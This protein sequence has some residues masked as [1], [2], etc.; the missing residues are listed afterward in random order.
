VVNPRAVHLHSEGKPLVGAVMPA[1]GIA[2]EVRELTPD[3]WPALE[4]LF[5]PNGACGGCWCMYWRL[6]EGERY[7]NVKGA[8]AKRR[9]SALVRH[10]RA[11]GLLA[12]V[13][14]EPVGWCAF[15]RRTELPRLNRAPSLRVDD[16]ERVWSLPC[17]F[18]KARW[19][20]TGV[21]SALLQATEAS[22]QARGA[23]I[24]EGYPIK[25][26]GK[27]KV[28]GPWAWTG[29]PAMFEAAGFTRADQRPKGK[30]RYRKALPGGA[31]SLDIPVAAKY[32]VKRR[33]K[34]SRASPRR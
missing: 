3:L 29:V 12:F 32:S 31:A 27:G 34:R 13:D 30:Q 2:M 7:E 6:R 22:L 28:P 20:G 16:A 33:G 5:G 24:A 15:E 11:H 10:G 4:R 21:A 25:P 23:R 14:E 9:F 26:S 8:R 17:F 18:V 19:R 1:K